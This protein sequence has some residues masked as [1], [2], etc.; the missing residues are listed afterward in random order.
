MK[1]LAVEHRLKLK[2]IKNKP[3]DLKRFDITIV[4]LTPPNVM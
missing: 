3:E 1:C 2:H 4:Y